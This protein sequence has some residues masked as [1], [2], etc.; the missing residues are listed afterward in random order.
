MTAANTHAKQ[1]RIIR[2]DPIKGNL[3]S[4]AARRLDLRFRGEFA[5]R[6]RFRK[7]KF[8]K[9]ATQPTTLESLAD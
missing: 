2:L 8:N 3:K 7:K 1:P 4:A 6:I 9:F 5:T